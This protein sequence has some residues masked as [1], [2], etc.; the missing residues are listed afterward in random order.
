MD[1]GGG[2]CVLC[3]D[4]NPVYCLLN[5]PPEEPYD[6]RRLA[7]LQRTCTAA[8]IEAGIEIVWDMPGDEPAHLHATSFEEFLVRIYFAEWTDWLLCGSRCDHGQIPDN[9]KEYL[10][11]MYSEKG[12]SLSST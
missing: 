11:R 7:A 4:W 5:E 3:A 12:R 1:T 9:L 2:H 8:E 6:Q 10:I